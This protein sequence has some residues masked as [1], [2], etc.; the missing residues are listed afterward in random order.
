[1]AEARSKQAA[2]HTGALLQLI[3]EPV[4]GTRPVGPGRTV[5]VLAGM[6]GGLI[7]GLGIVVLTAQPKK[8]DQDKDGERAVA[9]RLHLS[10]EATA[11]HRKSALVEDP[12]AEFDEA[13]SQPASVPAHPVPVFVK[14]ATASAPTNVAVAGAK[15]ELKSGPLTFRQALERIATVQGR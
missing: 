8:V 15:N 1:M 3:G 6:V 13:L 5:I 10:G 14:G 4:T 12:K 7:V 11:K 2:A 9:T